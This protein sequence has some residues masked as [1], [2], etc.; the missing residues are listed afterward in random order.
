MGNRLAVFLGTVAIAATS[1]AVAMDLGFVETFKQA[2]LETG[3]GTEAVNRRMGLVPGWRRE[4]GPNGP[5]IVEA[6]SWVVSEL[7]H[8]AADAAVSD[9]KGMALAVASVLARSMDEQRTMQ[10]CSAYGLVDVR[11][12]KADLVDLGLSKVSDSTWVFERQG[13]SLLVTLST[14]ELVVLTLRAAGEH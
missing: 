3:G 2:C 10:T 13:T 11:A 14:S 9:V 4:Q 7:D 6:T 8:Q 1:Q 12:A 5:D